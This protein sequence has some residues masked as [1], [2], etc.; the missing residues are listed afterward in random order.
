MDQ[1][2]VAS[3][4][5]PNGISLMKEHIPTFKSQENTETRKLDV[6]TLNTE[7]SVK[8]LLKN[9]AFM[10]YSVFKPTTGSPDREAADLVSRLQSGDGPTS[11]VMV[12]RKSRI[13]CECDIVTTLQQMAGNDGGAMFGGNGNANVF[14]HVAGSDGHDQV[15]EDQHL[16]Q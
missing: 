8:K 9:D 10:Y 11:S 16:A 2:L 13:S 3:T 5:S 1:K 6:T 4:G 14:H 7:A 15:I 12:D